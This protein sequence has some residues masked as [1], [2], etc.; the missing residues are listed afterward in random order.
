MG[1]LW[2]EVIVAVSSFAMLLTEC[3]ML[4]SQEPVFFIIVA[5]TLFFAIFFAIFHIGTLAR[6]L[7]CV[8]THVGVGPS[9]TLAPFVVMKQN[10]KI[11][12]KFLY[13]FRAFVKPVVSHSVLQS[14]LSGEMDRVQR[15]RWGMMIQLIVK[16]LVCVSIS[17]LGIWHNNP[18]MIVFGVALLCFFVDLSGMDHVDAVGEWTIFQGIGDVNSEFST[19]FFAA[20]MVL[21]LPEDATLLNSFISCCWEE[22][23]SGEDRERLADILYYIYLAALADQSLAIPQ[24]FTDDVKDMLYDWAHGIGVAT[25]QWWFLL[26]YLVW[27]YHCDTE[28]SRNLVIWA[29]QRELDCTDMPTRWLQK[30]R[31]DLLKFIIM[32]GEKGCVVGEKKYKYKVLY[33]NY[34][35][36]IAPTYDTAYRQ[37]CDK[38]L[39]QTEFTSPKH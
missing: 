1:K 38:Y 28:D 35:C 3:D 23:K 19:R 20:Q 5:L 21:Y 24:S 17:V 31:R 29:L 39:S 7:F 30:K 25:Y 13:T 27:S 14:Y 36:H 11:S 26:L 2:I 6:Y 16:C 10:R 37:V 15:Y 22:L 4:L 18:V 9:I 12:M 8:A 33:K 32:I 34:Y